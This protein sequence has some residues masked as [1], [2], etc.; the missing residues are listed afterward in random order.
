MR[1]TPLDIHSHRFARRIGG[2]DR[3][4]VDSFLRSIADD[5]ESL[6]RENERQLGQMRHLEQRV[7]EL[8]G[9]EE[10]LKQTLLTA[11]SVGEEIRQSAVKESEILMRE[12]EVQGEKIIDAA[13]RRAARLAEEIREMKSLR[14]RL[15][16]AMRTS[17]E[18]HLALIEALADEEG[19]DPLMEFP[20]SRLGPTAPAL[21]A[22]GERPQ[23]SEADEDPD[24]P[25][26]ET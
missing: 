15:A 21:R 10:L 14:T 13:H 17:I 1:I 2:F 16:S 19:E 25:R 20:V 24:L 23:T 3:E 8:A 12:A 7:E 6:L 4:E 9:N 11:Q 22:A 18:T 5:Y 26:L